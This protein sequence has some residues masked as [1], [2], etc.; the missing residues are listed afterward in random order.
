MKV[1][2]ISGTVDS[3]A[4]LRRLK[5]VLEV[6]CPCDSEEEAAGRSERL[7]SALKMVGRA[8]EAQPR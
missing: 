1:V 7:A 6:D 5:T 2:P 8:L 4:L 3:E